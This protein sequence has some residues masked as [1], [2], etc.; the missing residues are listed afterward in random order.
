MDGF[1]G[2]TRPRPE[3]TKTRTNSTVNVGVQ[4]AILLAS[5]LLTMCTAEWWAGDGGETSNLNK[6]A[7]RVCRDLC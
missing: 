5:E 2:V 3:S 7:G 4:A 1:D 6:E